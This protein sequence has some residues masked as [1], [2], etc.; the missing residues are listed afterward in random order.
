MVNKEYILKNFSEDDVNEA[1]KI[2]ENYKLA[3]EKDITI[4]SNS[5]CPPNIWSF[6]QENCQNSDF[7]IVTNGLFE[8][9]ERRVIAFNNKY[10]I[11]YPI[12]ALQIRNKSN[13]SNLR[14]K[15]YLG[16][17]LSLG[18]DRNK[19]GDV[20]V[21][22]DRAYVPVMEDISSY[23]LN[24]LA[25]IGKSPVEIS[26]LYDLVDLPSIDFDEISINVQSLRLDSVV[27]KLANI[28]RSKAI[29]LL[30]SSKV[31]VNYVKS[32]DKS[33]ELLKGTRL[34]IRGNGKYIVGDII[35]ETRSGKQRI[36]VKKYV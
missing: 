15:D 14:H 10:N 20:V 33:Q 2:Y 22:D 34:T 21:K 7:K 5:F 19:I 18:I 26:I 13:F 6:F 8:E 23:I 12:E 31:L 30:D 29:E 11:D 9:A 16:A 3:F 1:I 35:G 25:S 24:N 36:I 17:I 32:K 27:A 4:F 28:S